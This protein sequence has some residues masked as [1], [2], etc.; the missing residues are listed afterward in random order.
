MATN[1]GLNKYKLEIL[2]NYNIARVYYEQKQNLFVQH[3]LNKYDI[4]IGEELSIITNKAFPIWER[5]INEALAKADGKIEQ[6]QILKDF[7]KKYNLPPRNNLDKKIISTEAGFIWEDFIEKIG[8]SSQIRNIYGQGV[9]SVLQILGSG[10]FKSTS[11]VTQG[12]KNIRNDIVI[13]DIKINSTDLDNDKRL[14]F[15]NNINRQYFELGVEVILGEDI[16]Y[17]KDDKQQ[18]A[19]LLSNGVLGAYL[20]NN[21]SL[22]GVGGLNL[23]AWTGDGHGKRFSDSSVIQQQLANKLKNANNGKGTLSTGY[24]YS[25]DFHFISQRLIN[26]ISPTTVGFLSG[27]DFVW[28]SEVLEKYFLYMALFNNKNE[29][30]EVDLNGSKWHKWNVKDST[31]YLYDQMNKKINTIQYKIQKELK[32]EKI[33]LK[34]KTSSSS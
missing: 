27:S 30:V 16:R 19:N 33:T 20:D 24:A 28:T 18:F 6:V 21:S 8:A 1:V 4:D 5:E 7:I 12:F 22:N 31:L 23:K 10:A 11:R 15:S 2:H 3:W 13:S 25:I 29:Q 17:R 32:Q 34:G 14:F 26:I 9:N